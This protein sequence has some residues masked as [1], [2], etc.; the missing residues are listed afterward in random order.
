MLSLADEEKALLI[1]VKENG[2][3]EMCVG[4]N[5]T[6]ENAENILKH[7]VDELTYPI[8]IICVIQICDGSLRVV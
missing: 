1:Y 6:M 7:E 8:T 2:A 5:D 3:E 4:G